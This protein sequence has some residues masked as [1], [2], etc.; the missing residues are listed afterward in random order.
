LLFWDTSALVPLLVK[1][2]R[3]ADVR[4]VILSDADILTSAI[5]SLE[6]TSALWRRRHAGTLPLADHERA[7]QRFAQLSAR[8]MEVAQAPQLMEGALR[9]LARHSLRSLDV[10]Q[11]ASA[12]L[13]APSPALL[14]FVTLDKK[15]A[16]AAREEGFPVLP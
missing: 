1:E 8:W 6:V 16:A 15:L 5:T 3:S 11:L 10:L 7:E 13:V 12:L 9:L 4:A 14:P 2:D